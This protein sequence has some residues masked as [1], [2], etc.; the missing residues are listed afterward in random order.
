LGARLD[1][2]DYDMAARGA[3]KL[4]HQDPADRHR[5]APRAAL[6]VT[7]AGRAVTSEGFS[8]HIVNGDQIARPPKGFTGYSARAPAP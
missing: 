2:E 5:P 3:N 7:P 8:F 1:P 4:K 6:T